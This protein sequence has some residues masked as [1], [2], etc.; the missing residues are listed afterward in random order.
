M[1]KINRLTM[2]VIVVMFFNGRD[3]R[4][5]NQAIAGPATDRVSRAGQLAVARSSG[6]R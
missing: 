3:S 6:V 2:G 5:W 1:T 4:G